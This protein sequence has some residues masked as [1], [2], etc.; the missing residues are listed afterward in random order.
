MSLETKNKLFIE[1]YITKENNK[2]HGLGLILCTNIIEN[3]SRKIE[4]ES[5]LGKGTTF[6][7]SL[8]IKKASAIPF[9]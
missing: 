9:G 6:Q 4:V 3:Q 7:I 1:Q 5:E 8:P 2:G